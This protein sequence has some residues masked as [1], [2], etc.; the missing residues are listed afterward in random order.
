MLAAAS[1]YF[2]AHFDGQFKDGL[3]PIVDILEIEPHVFAL[4][5]DYMYDSSCSVSDVST[6]QQVLSVASVLQID[7]LVINTA[8]ALEKNLKVDNCASMLACAIQ[9][10]VPELVL[11][12]EALAHEAFVDVAS[13]PAFWHQAY[14]RYFRA[15]VSSSRLKSRCLRRSPRG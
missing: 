6:L 15:T 4:A 13:N 5:L 7:L 8:I 12:A 10:H 2:A 9:H 1:D 11:R 14:W 3:E